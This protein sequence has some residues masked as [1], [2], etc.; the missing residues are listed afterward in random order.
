MNVIQSAICM[1]KVLIGYHWS[2]S[3]ESN[4]IPYENAEYGSVYGS[5]Y[6]TVYGTEYGAVYGTE[7]GTVYGP[8]YGA[9]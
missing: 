4:G 6:G 9:V 8:E 7:Y 5:V 1:L 2:F 3:M